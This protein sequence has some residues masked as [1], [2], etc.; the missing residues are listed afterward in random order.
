MPRHVQFCIIDAESYEDCSISFEAFASWWISYPLG[1]TV[2]WRQHQIVASLGL[3]PLSAEQYTAFTTGIIRE[4]TLRPLS[5]EQCAAEPSGYWYLSGIIVIPALRRQ[6]TSPLQTLIAATLKLWSKSGHVASSIRCCALGHADQG[7]RLLGKL[8][9][10]QIS[11][12]TALPDEY[13]LYEG[14]YAS[15]DHHFVTF[16][17]PVAGHRRPTDPLCSVWALCR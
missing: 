1:N 8:G 6:P 14:T 7:R 5:L 2:V 4:E 12:G 9:F 11:N 16:T 13:P 15:P 17:C 3:W 10:A